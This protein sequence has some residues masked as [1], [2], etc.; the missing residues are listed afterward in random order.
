MGTFLRTSRC[1]LDSIS[2][3]MSCL[4]LYYVFVVL[5]GNDY[6]DNQDICVDDA[7]KRMQLK[8]PQIIRRPLLSVIFSC[9]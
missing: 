5:L 1:A 3:V 7:C 6:F 4:S 9:C 8:T 2:S